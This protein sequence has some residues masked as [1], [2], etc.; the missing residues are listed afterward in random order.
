M[1]ASLTYLAS[2][3]VLLLAPISLAQPAP[4][5]A[6]KLDYAGT[7]AAPLEPT[8]LVTYRK[9]GDRE[10]HL[11]V[12]N[13]EG[14]KA[15][16]KRACFLSVHGG[17]WV[18]GA[19]RRQYPFA[20]HFAAKGMVGIS[21]EYRLLKKDNVTPFDCVAD[22][23]S[24]IR[25]IKEHAAELG[26]DAEKI[27]ANGGSAGAH[28]AAGM[29]MFD[30]VDNPGDNLKIDPKPA[31]LVLHYP[32][33]DTSTAGYGNKAC[34]PKWKDISPLHQV[35]NGTPPTILFHGTGDQTTPFAGA[36]AF[37]A[38]MHEAG[39]RCELVIHPGGKHG[40]FMFEKELYDEVEKKT[41]AFLQSL[42]LID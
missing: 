5:A 35:K 20:A 37:D 25:Y 33:I 40:Y 6:P 32:V 23:R 28:V 9:A 12:F 21:V 29:A 36:K 38:A 34:G 24:A 11:H 10:L 39:N 19:P 8:R 15:S 30:G 1:N 16:D 2:L 42:K 18:N 41:E 27:V 31:A 14:W 17:G 4:P 3:T 7:L 22:G 13:P 26:I